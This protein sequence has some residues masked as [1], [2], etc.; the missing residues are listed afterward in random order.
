[1]VC[2]PFSLQSNI[3]IHKALTG[4]DGT[5]N[6]KYYSE[7]AK[8]ESDKAA[9]YAEMTFPEFFLDFSDGHLYCKQGKNV[10]FYIDGNG[11]LIVEVA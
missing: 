6:S 5:D 2:N 10:E 4:L 1:M 7:I 3:S 8:M 9:S 11:H